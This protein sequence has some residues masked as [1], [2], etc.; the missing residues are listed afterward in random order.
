[1]SFWRETYGEEYASIA[2][3]AL[4]QRWVDVYTNEG[5]TSGA[6]SWGTYQAPYYLLL[7]WSGEFS[8]VSTLVHEMGHSVHG[9]LASKNQ[10]YQDADVDLFIAEVGSVASQS[11]FGEWMLERTTDP[12]ERKMLLDYALT[13]I[14]N[15]FVTQIF[16]HEFEASVHAMAESGQALTAD[17]MGDAYVALTQKYY[18]DAIAEQPLGRIYWARIDHFFRNFYVW[19]FF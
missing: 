18:G 2:Q 4:D 5:K 11:L 7:N 10:S 12:V 14:R 15:T 1:M 13:S 19:V 17:T 16:F 9:V 3:Q 8:A 6:Y